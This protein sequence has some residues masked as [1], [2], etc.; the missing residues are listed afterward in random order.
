MS[1]SALI[2]QLRELHVHKNNLA[3]VQV[4]AQTPFGQLK[5][6][7]HKY[8]QVLEQVASSLHITLEQANDDGSPRLDRTNIW[9]EKS[10]DT[11]F[12]EDELSD[13][14]VTD[15]QLCNTDSSNQSENGLLEGIFSFANAD[16]HRVTVAMDTEHDLAATLENNDSR[17]SETESESEAVKFALHAGSANSAAQIGTNTRIPHIVFRCYHQESAGAEYDNGLRAEFFK[18]CGNHPLLSPL[19]I[20]NEWARHFGANQ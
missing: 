5:M 10:H 6:R 9:Q 3:W 1:E 20:G 4:Y 12:L 11:S 19:P 13:F 14:G 2:A 16:L 15:P 17:E 18:A 8:I 7:W